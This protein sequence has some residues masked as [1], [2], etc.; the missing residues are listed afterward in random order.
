MVS[1]SKDTSWPPDKKNHPFIPTGKG[2][3]VCNKPLITHQTQL[4][5][6]FLFLQLQ[7]HLCLVTYLS[8]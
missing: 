5:S 8:F 6:A 2:V 4:P 1:I 3:K 7:F